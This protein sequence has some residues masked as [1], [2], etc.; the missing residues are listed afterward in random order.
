MKEL[1]LTFEAKGFP[2]EYLSLG[3]LGPGVPVRAT[4]L[5]FGPQLLAKVLES[6]ETQEQSLALVFHYADEKGLRAARPGRPARA[7]RLPG[8]GAGMPELEGIG[9][10]A[11]VDGR[12]AAARD[13]RPRE[14][15]RDEF[16][17]EP[18]LEI[19]DLDA[20]RVRRSRRDLG[21]RAARRAGQAEAVPRPPSCGSSPSCSSSCPRPATWTSRSSVFFFDEAHLLFDGATDAFLESVV[22]TVRLIR[23]KGVGVFFV[24]QVP[25]DVAGRRARPARE[26]RAARAE[27]VHA[28]R[29]QGAQGGRLDLPDLRV[30]R[31][32]EAADVRGD[33]RGAPSRSCRTRRA[34]AGR[35]H[36][37][38]RPGVAHRA[39]GRRRGAA[40]ASPRRQ[41]RR[42]GPRRRA[43]ARSWRRGS[44]QAE[45]PTP[46]PSRRRPRKA[47]APSGVSTD[48]RLP[49]L[50]RAGQGARAHGHAAACS[51][52]W[53]KRL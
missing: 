34:D 12:R 48:R 17:G 33:R 50:D 1:G 47:P 31:R 52:C 25:D 18:Q 38:A 26:P 46:S 14:R 7:A 5:D 24:T 53:K 39:G 13:R 32:G 16:F 20:H 40:K 23:S 37:P 6:N 10:I 19:V 22:Q 2:V 41:V 36:P 49:R 27:G 9:G 8:I 42:R 4:V 45:E 28:R 51:G 11:V 29:R 44:T 30:L 35:P 3:G 43:R 15:W 21:P